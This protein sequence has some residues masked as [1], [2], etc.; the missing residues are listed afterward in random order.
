ML[1]HCKINPRDDGQLVNVDGELWYFFIQN[2]FFALPARGSVT[3][4]YTPAE[5][6]MRTILTYSWGCH[7]SVFI[8]VYAD[9]PFSWASPPRAPVDLDLGILLTS[10]WGLMIHREKVCFVRSVPKILLTDLSCCVDLD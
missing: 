7:W 9:E 4:L 8:L 10:A 1:L 5:S 3:L 6:R 2:P